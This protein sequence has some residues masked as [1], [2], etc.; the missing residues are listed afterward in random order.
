MKANG[1]SKKER[2]YLNREVQALFAS[3]DS[4]VAYPFR[5]IYHVEPA[6]DACVK[7]LVSVPKKKIKRA[8]GRNTVKRRLRESY[9]MHKGDL[10][11]FAEERGI[12]VRIGFLYLSSEVL[13]SD[14]ILKAVQTALAKLPELL[15]SEAL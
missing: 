6:E 3:R 2:L 10:V 15:S 1:L 7:I 13:P 8:T 14:K 4:F 9:R 12:V 11:T 5:V